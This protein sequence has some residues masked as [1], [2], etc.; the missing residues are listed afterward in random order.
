MQL[1]SEANHGDSELLADLRV[2]EGE[3]RGPPLYQPHAHA[4]GGEHRGVLAADH[5]TAQYRQRGRYALQ[6]KN[7]VGVV[8][9][10]IREVDAVG[11]V[12]R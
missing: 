5:A 11:S 10:R 2:E 1:D 7:R 12:G 4:E 9:A 6:P 8:N 3:Q